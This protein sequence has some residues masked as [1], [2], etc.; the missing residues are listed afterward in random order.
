MLGKF[1]SEEDIWILVGE[2]VK[3]MI[4]DEDSDLDY[5]LCSDLIIVE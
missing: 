4:G 1:E 3:F 2:L 5:E